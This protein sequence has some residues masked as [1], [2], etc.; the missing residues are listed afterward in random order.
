MSIDISTLSAAELE[1]LR[2]SIDGTIAA[3][4]AQERQRVIDQIRG[5]L[6]ENDM[7][8]DDLPRSRVGGSSTR[9]SKVPPKYRDPKNPATTWSGRGRKPKW[10]EAH[11]AAGGSMESLEI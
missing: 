3:R 11:L 2:E 9:G 4:R 10:V 5:I 7:S 8:W 1:K 6:A